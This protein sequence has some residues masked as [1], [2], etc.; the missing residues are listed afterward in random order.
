MSAVAAHNSNLPP[1]ILI[2]E[3]HGANAPTVWRYVCPV[4]SHIVVSSVNLKSGAVCPRHHT[5]LASE[6]AVDLTPA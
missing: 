1:K 5:T 6:T 4:D 3:A 2:W